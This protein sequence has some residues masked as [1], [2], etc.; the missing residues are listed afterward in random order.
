MDPY[1]V[2]REWLVTGRLSQPDEGEM[3]SVG[4]G[5]PWPGGDGSE[6]REPAVRR[7]RVPAPGD[8]E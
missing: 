1:L 7:E 3:P 6:I 8:G 4:G 5:R 2:P